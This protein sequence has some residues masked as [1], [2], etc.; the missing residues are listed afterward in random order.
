MTTTENSIAAAGFITMPT[1][2]SIQKRARKS[3][4]PT[5]PPIVPPPSSTGSIDDTVCH[6]CGYLGRTRS[7]S[8]E[9]NGYSFLRHLPP[10]PGALPV[11]DNTQHVRACHLCALLLDKQRELNHTTNNFFFKGFFRST[12][13]CH[14]NIGL[15]SKIVLNPIEEKEQSMDKEPHV[16]EVSESSSSQSMAIETDKSIQ[17]SRTVPPPLRRT[18]TSII[19]NS[20]NC[21][22]LDGMSSLDSYL[23]SVRARFLSDYASVESSSKQK[24]YDSCHLCL[25][26]KPH[27]TLYTIS[28]TEF[29][30]LSLPHVDVCTLCYYNLL[31]QYKKQ[32]KTYCRPRPQCY[33][34]RCR[35]NFIDWEVK[36]LETE[37]LPFLLSLYNENILHEQLYDN[38][39]LALACEQCFYRLLFQYIDQ[40]RRNIPIQQRTYSWQCTYSYEN[41]HYLNTNDFFYTSL[42]SNKTH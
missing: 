34:C 4:A 36:L 22:I 21:H 9:K 6:L 19:N 2:S 25:S 35:I 11:T 28:K 15:S 17:R 5:R 30:F 20:L 3:I 13:S 33:V 40:E 39:R 16:E 7:I 37:H 32:V 29:E 12:G 8:T 14:T 1:T 27:S 41:E 31:D 26:I 10:A 24:S 23:T 18:T 42:S 38:Q